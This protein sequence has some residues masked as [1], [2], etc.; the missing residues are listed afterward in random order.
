VDAEEQL[1]LLVETEFVDPQHAKLRA[2]RTILHV[3]AIDG[4]PFRTPSS[5]ALLP[6]Y[7]WWSLFFR[8]C[9]ATGT[10]MMNC[11]HITHVTWL[12]GVLRFYATGNLRSPQPLSLIRSVLHAN[13]LLSIY[14]ENPRF[15]SLV[16]ESTSRK[17]MRT[18]GFPSI[19]NSHSDIFSI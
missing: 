2:V 5:I 10:S 18:S 15:S 11:S 1:A 17:R 19:R 14:L 9:G 12:V 3:H 7:T 16:H 6:P 8:D 13:R 4:F